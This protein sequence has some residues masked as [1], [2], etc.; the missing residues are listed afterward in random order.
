MYLYVFHNAIILKVL[1][2]AIHY[3][4]DNATHKYVLDDASI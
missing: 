1:D 4:F 3:V 2:D